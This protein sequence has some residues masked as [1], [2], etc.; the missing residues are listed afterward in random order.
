MCGLIRPN[1]N[2]HQLFSEMLVSSVNVF[3]SPTKVK[4][5]HEECPV[6]FATLHDLSPSIVPRMWLPMFEELLTKSLAPFVN[7]TLPITPTSLIDTDVQTLSFFPTL[8][9]CRL[10]NFY[11]ADA[12]RRK[13]DICSKNHPGHFIG[14]NYGFEVMQKREYPNV[15]LPYF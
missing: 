4:L 6:L 5:L 13:E 7:Y 9:K 15:P 1:E 2:I 3:D 8:P 14:S 12:A 11:L 10:R